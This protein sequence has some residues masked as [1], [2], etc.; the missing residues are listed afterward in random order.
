MWTEIWTN[1]VM[2]IVASLGGISGIAAM[3]VAI[4][5]GRVNVKK[6]A[7][8]AAENI[9]KE[10]KGTLSIDINDIVELKLKKA[11]DTITKWQDAYYESQAALTELIGAMGV[12]FTQSS[13]IGADQKDAFVKALEK[14]REVNKQ[15]PKVAA[16]KIERIQSETKKKQITEEIVR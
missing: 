6:A 3:I 10:T 8:E 9:L 12:F 14:A 2:P 5:K 4:I 7:Q 11:T 13:I 1:Y 16:L 15:V